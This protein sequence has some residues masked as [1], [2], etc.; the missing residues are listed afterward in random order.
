MKKTSGSGTR[1]H[2]LY[3]SFSLPP[4]PQTN[5]R[6]ART[7]ISESLN[8]RSSMKQS[9]LFFLDKRNSLSSYCGCIVTIFNFHIHR[10]GKIRFSNYHLFFLYTRSICTQCT[11][12]YIHNATVNETMVWRHRC[13]YRASS[14]KSVMLITL[15][16]RGLFQLIATPGVL[17]SFIHI[18]IHTYRA[19]A[20]SFVPLTLCRKIYC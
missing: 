8:A 12:I 9:E 13:H 19:S 18:H 7:V 3:H 16:S 6:V 4:C 5:I 10:I 20:L 11:P 15:L 17:F 2:W 1:D 14:R